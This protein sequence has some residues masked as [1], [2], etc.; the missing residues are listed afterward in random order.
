MGKASFMALKEYSPNGKGI[1][2]P[3]EYT[4]MLYRPNGK[5]IVL[6][7]ILF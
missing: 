7:K 4:F 3:L 5:G 6:W 2:A 1:M